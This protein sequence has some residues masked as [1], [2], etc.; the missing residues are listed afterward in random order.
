VTITQTAFVIQ[1]ATKAQ[2]IDISKGGTAKLTAVPTLSPPSAVASGPLSIRPG[3][4]PI[5]IAVASTN[6]SVAT[7]NPSQ[8]TFHGGDQKQT[9]NVQGVSAGNATVKLLGI[10]YDF[11]QPQASIQVVVK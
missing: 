3:A 10:A 1:E 7:T 9:F 4:S 5:V 8:V 11:G 6:P 2:P